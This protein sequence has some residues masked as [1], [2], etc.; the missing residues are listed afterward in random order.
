MVFIKTIHI[1]RVLYCSIWHDKNKVKS[2]I[3]RKYSK[4][5]NLRSL[6]YYHDLPTHPAQ[7]SVTTHFLEE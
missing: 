1:N 5:K 4:N 2:W 7:S 6:D 3:I